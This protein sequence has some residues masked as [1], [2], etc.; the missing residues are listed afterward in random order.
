MAL[1]PFS[2]NND[3]ARVAKRDG[4]GASRN[5][6][7]T[8]DERSITGDREVTDIIRGSERRALLRDTNTLLPPP[9]A[10]DG[11][12]SFWATTTNTKDTVESRQRLGYT[13]IT[14]AEAPS[15]Y[16]LG[17]LKSGD[18]TTDRIMCNEMVAMKI[19][20]DIWKEDMMD[21]H[22]TM[23]NE[24][25]K[26]IKDRISFDED[27]RGKKIGWTG[28][29]FKDGKDQGFDDLGRSLPPSLTGIA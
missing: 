24:R 20:L 4:E 5:D 10:V 7:A 8:T 21:L 15:G 2:R 9:P 6:R 28:E 1:N 17:T 3:D 11:Y 29:G 16:D 13:F 25:A 26:S 27:G 12:H 18:S 23:P 19:P 14:R 22:H